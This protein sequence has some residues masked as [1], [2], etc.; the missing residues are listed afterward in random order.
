MKKTI[1]ILFALILSTSAQARVVGVMA[2]E[3]TGAAIPPAFESRIAVIPQKADKTWVGDQIADALKDMVTPDELGYIAIEPRFTAWTNLW[4]LAITNHLGL[5]A[6]N[7]HGVTRSMIGAVSTAEVGVVS[8]KVDSLSNY[9]ATAVS[10]LATTNFVTNSVGAVSNWA[11]ATITNAIA[12]A[13]SNLASTNF[14]TNSVGAV[15]NYASV[16]LATAQYA[17]NALPNYVPLT[18]AMTGGDR[19]NFTS[20][21]VDVLSYSSTERGAHEFQ[22]G[23]GHFYG[24]YR[25]FNSLSVSDTNSIT[26]FNITSNGAVYQKRSLKV[27]DTATNDYAIGAIANGTTNYA[28][29]NSLIDLGDFEFTNAVDGVARSLASIANAN[30]HSATSGMAWA[31]NAAAWSSNQVKIILTNAWNRQDSVTNAVDE[32]AR[33]IAVYAYDGYT[34]STPRTN[35]I[36]INGESKQ[37]GSNPVFTVAGSGGITSGVTSINAL[38]GAVHLVAGSNVTLAVGATSVTINAS[39]SGGDASGWSGF[40]ATQDVDFGEYGIEKAASVGFYGNKLDFA[41]GY[42]QISENSTLSFIPEGTTYVSTVDFSGVTVTGLPASESS[43]VVTNLGDFTVSAGLFGGD[44]TNG[45]V[46]VYDAGNGGYAYFLSDSRIAMWNPNS[47]SRTNATSLWSV[48][49]TNEWT[50]Y[51]PVWE[52]RVNA[53]EAERIAA[54]AEA[55]ASDTNALD[56]AGTRAMTGTNVVLARDVRSRDSSSVG[57]NGVSMGGETVAGIYGAAFGQASEAGTYGIAAGYNT[58]AGELGAAFGESTVADKYGLAAGYQSEAGFLGVALGRSAKGTN[59][60]FVFA[61]SQ[62]TVFDRTA[63]EASNS[64]SFR[65]ENGIYALIGTNEFTVRATDGV[66]WNGFDLATDTVGVTN[67]Q[68][69]VTLEGQMSNT[70]T[71]APADDDLAR[72]GWVRGQLAFGLPYYM[73]TNLAS[74]AWLPTNTTGLGESSAPAVETWMNFGV[75]GVGHYCASMLLS[76]NT[77]SGDLAGP[78]TIELFAYTP[79][80]AGRSLSVKPEIYWTYDLGSAAITNGDF[81]ALPQALTVGVTNNLKYSITWPTQSPT[82][83]YYVVSRLKV[84]ARG[85]N[86]TNIVLGVGGTAASYALLQASSTASLGTRGA[87]QSI[88]RVNGTNYAASFDAT[89]RSFSNDIGTISGG[90]GTGTGNTWATN[91]PSAGQMLYASEASNSNLYWAA[92]PAGGSGAAP[93]PMLAASNLTAVGGMVTVAVSTTAAQC[94][95]MPVGTYTTTVNLVTGFTGVARFAMIYPPAV[96]NTFKAGDWTNDAF[97][98]LSQVTN[99]YIS[100][101]AV[102]TALGTSRWEVLKWFV[103]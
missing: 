61:D 48:D 76:S 58:Y 19:W 43:Q 38:T 93:S 63:A 33:A 37:I 42:F 90:G 67:N 11:A 69:G 45:A 98:A 28:D 34:N 20:N 47:D 77:F 9:T 56:L 81:S 3:T 91:T 72:A 39:E 88:V 21:G 70:N 22:L 4:N 8:A 83:D 41:E 31:S 2:N 99:T 62:E 102:A 71:A 46:G 7:V 89:T 103:P 14:V 57:V 80:G 82:G 17:S 18:D 5:T 6:S 36:T 10:T 40:A 12:S 95:L 96:T 84:T 65:A 54:L 86:T 55:Y 25:F 97:I 75:T 66:R 13:T 1:F 59:G 74:V 92:A 94:Y 26:Y 64:V 51:Y 53:T 35:T 27:G 49:T 16:A 60:S 24:D 79:G 78:S 87:T 52:G 32:I 68:T 15:S 73:T 30:A 100:A 85:N 101:S 50:N 44:G 23:N 29:E